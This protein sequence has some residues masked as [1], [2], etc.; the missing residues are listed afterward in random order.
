MRA[1]SADKTLKPHGISRKNNE[2]YG[3][4][5]LQKQT[6]CSDEKLRLSELEGH[7]V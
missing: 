7:Q 3:G 5:E 2:E 1:G 6:S 4:G